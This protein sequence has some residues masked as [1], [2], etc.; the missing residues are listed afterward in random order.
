MSL[1][2]DVR[3]ALRALRGTPAFTL[4]ALLILALGM[5]SAATIF[6]AVNAVLLRPLPY[7]EAERLVAVCETN[8]EVARF[9]VASPPDVE[10][11][12][13][14]AGTLESVGFA[15]GWY[16][17]L[18]AGGAAV[19]VDGG[20]AT[21]G[22]FRA[23][24]VAPAIGRVFE[25]RDLAPGGARVAVLSHGLWAERF[26]SDVSV[27]G[28]LISLDGE[29]YEVV[30]VLPPTFVAPELEQVRLWTPPPWD[31]RDETRRSWRGFQV[32][33]RL[34]AGRTRPQAEAEL[35]A[36]QA[37][38]AREHPETN[39][40]WGVRVVSLHER[41]TGA[42]R[43]ALA[44]FSGAVGL[45]LLI[46]CANLAHLM[47]VRASN[48]QR[49][50]AVRTAIGAGRGALL[51]QLLTES[52]VLA[53][54]GGVVGLL[55]A[56]W[57]SG[58]FV[59]L[60]PP[61]IP[62]LEQAHVDLA[63]F[64]FTF[65]LALLTA[66]VSGLAPAL[67][68]TRVDLSRGLREGMG[69]GKGRGGARVRRLLVSAEVALTLVLLVGAGLLAR[70]F[71][72]LV[73]WDP[74]FDRSN[75]LAFS[76]FASTERYADNAAIGGLWPRVEA[77]LAAIPGVTSVATV[78]AGPVFGGIEPG[79][80]AIVGD[81]P[82][83]EAPSVRWYD[84]SP[85]YFRTLGLP[86][87]RGRD[88]QESDVAGSRPVAVI[89]ETF[90]RSHFAGRDAV[91]QRVRMLDS[92]TE[93]EIVGVVADVPPFWAGRPTEPELWWSNRQYPRWGT[94]IIVRT[95][96]D[97]GSVV[98]TLRERLDAIDPDLQTGAPVTLDDLVG[99]R[100]IAPRFNLTLVA[101][102]ALI[103]LAL[104]VAGVY[105]V[106][107]Y[108]VSL[109]RREIGIRMAL[110]AARRDV[111]WRVLAEGAS[112]VGAGIVLGLVGAL[113][114]SHLLAGLLFG[115][116]PR[117]PATLLATALLLGAVALAACALPALRASRLD[118]ARVL[119]EE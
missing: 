33:G 79:R 40:E 90:A 103:A 4:S 68:A 72:T 27:V 34:A 17:L 109:R 38:L 70:S 13:E 36:L 86:V 61:G 29:N 96:V 10:D 39:G 62:R 45:L 46:A 81:P 3:Y 35:V 37:S 115:V 66:V 106:L 110:G 98:R 67:F 102:L 107:A 94:F 22:W 75:V 41:I 20:Y 84:A 58:G 15:R 43:P 28:R 88:L 95:G 56:S 105:G 119:R 11:W 12:A 112:P 92:G 76:A 77:S 48:R 23:L 80:F 60:A 101:F 55:L 87:R 63:V 32:V 18:R 97:P 64:G 104:A 42:T 113:A 31:P 51:R 73:R 99:Q 19:G 53:T 49:E 26:G 82:P 52:V 74:G 9:C 6:T 100:L 78:S 89:N 116:A 117:D 7:A 21:P 30:G 83:A 1:V 14:S 44:V 50:M 118:P 93:V 59:R 54:A 71:A 24:R 47:L 85:G 16:F 69:A 25:P 108:A 5:G 114:L 111:V 8:P 91:G 65:L 2:S 57:A